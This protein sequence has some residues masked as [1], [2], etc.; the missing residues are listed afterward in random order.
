MSYQFRKKRPWPTWRWQIRIFLR[1]MSHFWA[2]IFFFGGV[3]SWGTDTLVADFVLRDIRGVILWVNDTR[4]LAD[5]VVDDNSLLLPDARGL[6]CNKRNTDGPSAEPDVIFDTPG[7]NFPLVNKNFSWGNY[8]T[9]TCIRI[10]RK[11]SKRKEHIDSNTR[12]GPRPRRY[13]AKW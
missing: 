11:N 10:P 1:G 13:F 5:I 8:V 3:C 9:R 12:C 2:A 7:S 6:H 4:G